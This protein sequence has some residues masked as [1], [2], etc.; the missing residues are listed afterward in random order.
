MA[1]PHWYKM[2]PLGSWGWEEAMLRHVGGGVE[3]A[4]LLAIIL[5]KHPLT[6]SHHDWAPAGRVI[7]PLHSTKGF[8]VAPLL[9]KLLSMIN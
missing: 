9:S 6:A 3:P 5:P 1:R 7:Q 8:A 2:A 4:S